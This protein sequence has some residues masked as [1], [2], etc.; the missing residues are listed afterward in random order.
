MNYGAL[1]HLM[2]AKKQGDT[3]EILAFI[4]FCV[5]AGF[6]VVCLVAYILH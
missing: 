3:V 5:F 1:R 4:A 6:A 2:K